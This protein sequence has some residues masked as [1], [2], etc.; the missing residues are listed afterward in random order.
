MKPRIWLDNFLVHI[1]VHVSQLHTQSCFSLSISV[2]IFPY[3]CWLKTWGK[4]MVETSMN[5]LDL[6]SEHQVFDKMPQWIICSICEEI[7]F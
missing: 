2:Y 5:N 4:S 3:D 7:A 6:V 1:Y